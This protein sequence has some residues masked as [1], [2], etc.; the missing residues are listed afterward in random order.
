MVLQCH[1]ASIYDVKC[2]EVTLQKHGFYNAHGGSKHDIEDQ[3]S[4][5]V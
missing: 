1:L 3:E 5:F 4:L 2:C